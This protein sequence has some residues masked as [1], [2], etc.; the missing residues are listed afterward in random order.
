VPVRPADEAE[1]PRR[2]RGS[3]FVA[4]ARV[5]IRR[6]RGT[7]RI[8]LTPTPDLVAGCRRGDRASWARLVARFETLV[9]TVAR[10]NGLGPEDAADVTQI[11]FKTLLEEIDRVREL[12]SLSSW[13][14]TVARRQSWR[15]LKK[16]EREPAREVEDAP[17]DDPFVDWERFAVLNDAV[18]QLGDPCRSLLTMLFLDP[19]QP[20]HA[21][22]ADRLGRAIGGI[23]PLRG[24]CLDKLRALLDEG[25]PW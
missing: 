15:M 22:I 7:D 11:T 13:L 1:P 19:S 8:G 4:D 6:Q 16:S 5:D 12:D 21:E 9:Y 3:S 17:G 23:G 10:R 14:A 20:S 2:V 25:G 24:R 18:E